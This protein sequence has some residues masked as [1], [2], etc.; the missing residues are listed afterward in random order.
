MG[1]LINK[2]IKHRGKYGS[3]GRKHGSL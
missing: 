1:I 2:L 3:N